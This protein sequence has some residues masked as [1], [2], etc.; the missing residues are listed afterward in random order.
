MALADPP[1]WMALWWYEAARTQADAL[2]FDGSRDGGSAFIFKTFP[3]DSGEPRMAVREP[4][5]G[6]REAIRICKYRLSFS[7]EQY[8]PAA[9]SGV[10]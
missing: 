7:I 3:S 6:S 10:D 8:L 4:D 9:R 2:R 5:A 1:T